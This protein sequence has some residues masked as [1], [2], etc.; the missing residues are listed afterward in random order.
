M[1]VKTSDFNRTFVISAV[2]VVADDRP[3]AIVAAASYE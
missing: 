1:N 2:A 3:Q